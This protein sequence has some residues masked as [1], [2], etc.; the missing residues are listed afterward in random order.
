MAHRSWSVD[1]SSSSIQPSHA[2]SHGLSTQKPF[3]TEEL[4]DTYFNRNSLASNRQNVARSQRTISQGDGLDGLHISL[5]PERGPRTQPDT[6]DHSVIKD[7]P[8]VTHH[9][10]QSLPA[11]STTRKPVYLGTPVNHTISNRAASLS[12]DD[13]PFI[14]PAQRDQQEQPAR[15]Y[16]PN[17][18]SGRDH[19]KCHYIGGGSLSREPSNVS[20]MSR[21]NDS[22]VQAFDMEDVSTCEAAGERTMKDRT[23]QS[24]EGFLV[25]LKHETDSLLRIPMTQ[26]RLDLVSEGG[27]PIGVEKA[28]MEY[29]QGLLST[30]TFVHDC[31]P[32]TLVCS[33][34]GTPNTGKDHGPHGLPTTQPTSSEN[35]LPIANQSDRTA[36]VG[37]SPVVRQRNLAREQQFKRTNQAPLSAIYEESDV[38]AGAQH[39]CPCSMCTD[40]PNGRGIVWFHLCPRYRAMALETGIQYQPYEG[41]VILHH[42]RDRSSLGLIIEGPMEERFLPAIEPAPLAATPVSKRARAPRPA[43]LELPSLR[44]AAS[45]NRKAVHHPIS[46]SKPL[47]VLTPALQRPISPTQVSRPTSLNPHATPCCPKAGKSKATLIAAEEKGT[48]EPHCSGVI[49]S[50]SLHPAFRPGR[51]QPTE[52][53]T[54]PTRS[55]SRASVGGDSPLL[56]LSVGSERARLSVGSSDLS[57]QLPVRTDSLGAPTHPGLLEPSYTHPVYQAPGW[58]SPLRQQFACHLAEFDDSTPLVSPSAGHERT[59]SEYLCPSTP[60]TASCKYSSISCEGETPLQNDRRGTDRAVT[61]RLQETRSPDPAPSCEILVQNADDLHDPSLFS[62]TAPDRYV[63]SL[64]FRPQPWTTRT[65]SPSLDHFRSS[66][67]RSNSPFLPTRGHHRSQASNQSV[68]Q[69]FNSLH[70]QR[71]S[72][73]VSGTTLLNG[74][75][76]DSADETSHSGAEDLERPSFEYDQQQRLRDY[77]AD[78]DIHHPGRLVTGAAEARRA[79]ILSSGRNIHNTNS[80][81]D[82]APTLNPLRT[83]GAAEAL[84]TGIATSTSN[85]TT[86]YPNRRASVALGEGIA[87]TNN[88][89]TSIHP[90]HRTSSCIN[91]TSSGNNTAAASAQ[92]TN[93]SSSSLHR[94]PHHQLPL[95]RS[96]LVQQNLCS[97]IKLQDVLFGA[98]NSS[99]SPAP[100]RPSI[101]SASASSISSPRDSISV[102]QH[103]Y[104]YQHRKLQS[105]GML[106]SLAA[107]GKLV[108]RGKR[109]EGFARKVVR[110]GSRVFNAGRWGEKVMGG[111]R[112]PREQHDWLDSDD[113]RD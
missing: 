34:V 11:R 10:K 53:T 26:R 3:S 97:H 12:L 80:R 45:D 22:Y 85:N 5:D 29:D 16:L 37:S 6:I 35:S 74:T 76:F 109:E 1:S 79:D 101:A 66:N 54:P 59:P 27:F 99:S 50:E 104:P 112:T 86:Q 7:A 98:N 95:R 51:T 61:P 41:R 83:V 46:Q 18:N 47:P 9:I 32:P 107:D 33:K 64:P 94:Q 4:W 89:T 106:D 23:Q 72:D 100:P 70:S 68:T 75:A 103:M 30:A 2:A 56:P 21:S 111:W 17:D 84:C 19:A 40:M 105:M 15:R 48:E 65:A 93:N 36:K 90:H 82:G 49:E 108:G 88:N 91:T 55:V 87:T 8:S 60:S 38:V 43:K 31:L 102:S 58:P 92:N 13:E 113:G 52:W 62:R 96:L 81:N 39:E 57:G 73:P 20:V 110:K 14:E 67:S 71:N 69:S 63:E 77:R 24:Q 78:S 42:G 25:D 44:S 28:K